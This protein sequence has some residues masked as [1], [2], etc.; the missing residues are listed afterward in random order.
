MSD[1]ARSVDAQVSSGHPELEGVGSALDPTPSAPAVV[2]TEQGRTPLTLLVTQDLEIGRDCD[3]LILLDSAISRRHLALSRAGSTVL[4]TDVGSLNGSTIDGRPLERS[5]RLAPGQIVRFGACTLTLATRVRPP[6]PEAG[7]TEVDAREV[8]ATSIGL[9]AEAVL[10]LGQAGAQPTDAGTVT[11]VFSDIE[12]STVRAVELGDLRWH[13]VLSVHNQIMRR[14]L[15]RHHGI[16]THS[17]GDGFM[18]CFR[19]ARS[20]LAFL[21]DAQRALAA[22]EAANP[23]AGLSVRAGVHTG[24]AV[25]GDDG[26][27]FG[28]HVVMASRIADQARGG[29]ILVSSLVRE[30]VEPRGDIVFGT[31]RSVVLKGLQGEHLVH[32]ILY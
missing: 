22:Y 15:A 20:A 5:H 30:I 32:Q 2:V 21:V 11:I 9:L 17:L 1:G 14:M 7:L 28:R 31:S 26:D 16:E 18:M 4:V 8:R 19:S 23:L 12:G 13:E 24:E 29:E 27:L 6:A 3:G 25:V 10:D